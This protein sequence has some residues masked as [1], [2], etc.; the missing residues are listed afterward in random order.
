MLDFKVQVYISYAGSQRVKIS[1]ILMTKHSKVTK[2][3][4]A[5]KLVAWTSQS[6]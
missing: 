6:W 5:N 2:N 1:E 4:K 3:I